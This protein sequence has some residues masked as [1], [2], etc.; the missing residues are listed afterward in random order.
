MKKLI[1]AL[2]LTLAFTISS[3]AQIKKS[4]T[5]EEVVEIK[6]MASVEQ[7]KKE[8]VS[9]EKSKKD[10]E[11]LTTYLGLNDKQN[12]DFYRLFEQKY[13]TIE[14]KNISDEKRKEFRINSS[15]Y[16]KH[17]VGTIKIS[18]DIF[19]F[20]SSKLKDN[21]LAVL[22]QTANMINNINKLF[23][24]NDTSAGRAGV[25]NATNISSN[26]KEQVKK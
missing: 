24:N 26:L 11:E 9:I 5:A 8:I 14:D 17:G 13:R 10:A 2:T 12:Q 22:T 3:N 20:Y 1:A 18:D 23:Y 25:S 16:T 19:N 4:T 15:E 21:V 7:N 6:E